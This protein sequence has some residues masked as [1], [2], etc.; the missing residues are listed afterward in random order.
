MITRSGSFPSPNHVKGERHGAC[1]HTLITIWVTPGTILQGFKIET[2][3]LSLFFHPGLHYSVV[4]GQLSLT[5]TSGSISFPPTTTSL[6]PFLSPPNPSP[7][8]TSINP[9]EIIIHTTS[10]SVTGN[11]PLHDLLSI[12]TQS[13]SIIIN[14]DLK[15][16]STTSPQPAKLHINTSS[17]SIHITTPLLLS[18]SIPQR[19]YQTTIS[20]LSSSLDLT[21]PHGSTTTLT[22]QSGRLAA[23]LHPIQ[24]HPH[25]SSSSSS[26]SYLST[27]STSGATHITLLNSRTHPALLRNLHA[28]H[29]HVSGSLDLYYPSQWEGSIVGE[30]VSGQMGIEWPGTRIV[31]D[32]RDGAR[33]R[34]IEATR[35]E[36]E[37]GGTL[38]F[39]GVSG[40][41]FLR[42]DG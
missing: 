23:T 24:Y 39:R 36:G 15:P 9:R 14:L 27:H 31:R 18:Q 38:G 16:A 6:S 13:G 2:Q 20:S 7:H 35:G 32:V 34:R 8:S 12:T 4:E 1:I 42:G 25:S 3:S 26:S 17:G 11:Y 28:T 40:R 29:V 19:D 37:G 22:T 41:G 30:T 21:I 10:G 33:G 5:S